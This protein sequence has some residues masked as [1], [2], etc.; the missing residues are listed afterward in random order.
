MRTSQTCLTIY[1]SLLALNSITYAA[2][3]SVPSLATGPGSSI[4]LSIMFDP[5]GS[6]LSGIQFDLQYDNSNMSIVVT[7]GEATGVSGKSI[8]LNG[9]SPNR[10]RFL[11]AGLNQ[12]VIGAGPLLNLLVN[13]A[14][15]ALAG[16]YSL[17]V[18]GATG[19]DA[20]GNASPVTGSNGT[21][22]VAG[23][24][25][26]RIQAAGVLN[27]A[28]LTAG[29]VA[30]GEIVTLIGSSIGPAAATVPTSSASSTNLGGVSVLIGGN[31]APL[32]YAGPNQINAIIPYEIA[33]ANSAQMFIM[34]NGELVAGLPLTVS[35]AMPAIFTVQSTGVGPGAI[36]NQD[37][38][39]NSPSN[40]AARGSV[41]VLFATGVGTMNPAPVDG[42]VT[43]NNPPLA[44]LPVSVQIGGVSA[45]VQYAGAA[46]GLIAG[47]LQVNCV[48]PENISPGE[49][50]FVEITVGTASSPRGVTVAIQ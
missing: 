44:S 27:G 23:T 19:T 50:V 41:V 4:S 25:G 20:L 18:S 7:P 14:P 48:V 29:P 35:A 32:L 46:P 12:N 30:P 42:Q 21:I 11:V 13:L 39:L 16:S 9:I 45:P 38:S 22:T 49:S 8:Y 10:L 37:S 36:L 24:S 17:V 1:V 31:P 26:S 43:G 47:V 28:S 6:S 2:E 33:G 40:P 34:N 5:Q 3:V 15:N